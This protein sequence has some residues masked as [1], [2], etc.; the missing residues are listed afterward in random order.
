[1]KINRTAT[2][3]AGSIILLAG[4]SGIAMASGGG[5]AATSHDPGSASVGDTDVNQ[6]PDASPSEP[7][8][9]DANETGESGDQ[10]AGSKGSV[11]EES[12]SKGSATGE[13]DSEG[14]GAES[15][16]DTNQGPDANPNEP[17]HQDANE[18]GESGNQE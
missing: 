14:S 18:T 2:A 4:V 16:A 13:S 17:G 11:A 1:M 12:G 8:H 10:Q 7:G 3:A 9:Q 6:G 15:D 5:N